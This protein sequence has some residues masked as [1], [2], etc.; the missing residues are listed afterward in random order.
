MVRREQITP[1]CLRLTFQSD[2][3]PGWI[4]DVPDQFITFLFPKGDRS[5][6]A[7]DR[8]F[9][10]DRWFSLPEDEQPHGR[11]YTVRAWRP[12]VNEVDVDMILH[13]GSTIGTDWAREVLPG[14]PMVIW[15]PRQAYDPPPN[16]EWLLL[17]GD[18]TGLPAI[19][20]IL[21]HLDPSVTAEVIIE[22]DS[23]A[24][25]QL[26]PERERTTVRWLHRKGGPLGDG[27]QLMQAVQAIEIPDLVG[28]AWGG[29][30]QRVSN[31]IGKY[32]RRIRG[33]RASDVCA[34]GY[35]I[36]EGDHA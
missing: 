26:L 6:P 14:E 20:A 10:W 23:P 8:D 32:L 22:V 28:Y 29:G 16:L 13:D 7:V 12:D 1:H 27:T 2:E 30:E 9:T 34:I 24:D 18:D 25:H 21:E 11:N 31:A 17:F 3:F 35:W 19:A 33:F 5:L 36:K 4:S 15:G